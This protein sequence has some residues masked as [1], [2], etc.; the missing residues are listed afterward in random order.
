MCYWG[1]GREVVVIPS[2]IKTSFGIDR[3][4]LDKPFFPAED[5]VQPSSWIQPQVLSQSSF[6]GCFPPVRK[7]ASLILHHREQRQRKSYLDQPLLCE[8]ESSGFVILV[9]LRAVFRLRSFRELQ[10]RYLQANALQVFCMD[11]HL[12]A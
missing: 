8:P 12:S 1:K 9:F 4:D 11:S 7:V 5:S 3:K 6:G 10:V 2:L